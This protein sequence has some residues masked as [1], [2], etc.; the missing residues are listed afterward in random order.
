MP[1]ESMMDKVDRFEINLELA[2]LKKVLAT[3]ATKH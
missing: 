3:I 1:A 2:E